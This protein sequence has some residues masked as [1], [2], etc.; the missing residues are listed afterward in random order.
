ARK[1]GA[2][3]PLSRL[4]LRRRRRREAARHARAR[5]ARLR[6]GP[7]RR[8]RGEAARARRLLPAGARAVAR[9][10]AA[11]G[12]GRPRRRRRPPAAAPPPGC[13]SASF[14]IA[15]PRLELICSDWPVDYGDVKRPRWQAGPEFDEAAKLLGRSTREAGFLYEGARVLNDSIAGIS[16]FKQAA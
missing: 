7:P 15:P 10:G 12:A 5:R 1:H 9:E 16:Y 4:L 11:P 8:D 2:E 3:P 13:V 14:S 6:V